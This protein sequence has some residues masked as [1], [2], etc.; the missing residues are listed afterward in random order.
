MTLWDLQI[1]AVCYLDFTQSANLF[2][3]GVL[4]ILTWMQL[5]KN[6]KNKCVMLVAR[7]KKP[8]NGDN[9]HLINLEIWSS[10]ALYYITACNDKKS[11]KD[12]W[13]WL[14]I[15]IWINSANRDNLIIK[16]VIMGDCLRNNKLCIHTCNPKIL[17]I[18]EKTHLLWSWHDNCDD[19]ML[20][21][22]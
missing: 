18:F 20:R 2:G 5:T 4:N 13:F 11:Q 6:T 10:P 1:I 8:I 16:A 19:L 9:I 14:W 21:T 17:Y 22:G 3:I 7:R 12:R 15:N